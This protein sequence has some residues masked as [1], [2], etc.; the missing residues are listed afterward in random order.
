MAQTD[1]CWQGP[2]FPQ[3]LKIHNV[4]L[5][6]DDSVMTVAALTLVILA[7]SPIALQWPDQVHSP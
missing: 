7:C 3:R 6:R 4:F 5:I 2:S 1:V